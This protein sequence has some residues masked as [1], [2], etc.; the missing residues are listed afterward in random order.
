MR[1]TLRDVF[2]FKFFFFLYSTAELMQVYDFMWNVVQTMKKK[3]N[4]GL[5]E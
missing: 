3:K 2:C 4:L 1:K 5:L